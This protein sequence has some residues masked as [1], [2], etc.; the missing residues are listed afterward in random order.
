MKRYH[1]EID[2]PPARGGGWMST[3]YRIYDRTLGSGVELATTT[4]ADT[5]QKIVDAL[6]AVDGF[7]SS[8]KPQP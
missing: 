4:G 7:A 2:A 1:F 5:A 3:I 8:Q 6:N